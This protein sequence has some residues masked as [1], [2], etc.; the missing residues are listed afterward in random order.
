MPPFTH[1]TG[2]FNFVHILPFPVF[3]LSAFEYLL[4][5]APP[6]SAGVSRN[7]HK[8]FLQQMCAKKI[9]DRAGGGGCY[10]IPWL[11]SDFKLFNQ[12]K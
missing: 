4:T 11:S 1:P 6:L 5:R 12:V 10:E 3:S 8:G 2:N 7:I 9:K